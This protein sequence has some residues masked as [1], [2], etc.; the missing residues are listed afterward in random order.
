MKCA[1]YICF[2]IL[3][4]VFTFSVTAQADIQQKISEN[5][6]TSNVQQIKPPEQSNTIVEVQGAEYSLVERAFSS[7]FVVSFVLLTLIFFS[8]L[9]WAILAAKWFYLKRIKRHNDS[10]IAAFWNS[11][12]INAFHETLN[13][14]PY[15]P[16]R[17]VF[18][19]GYQELVKVT[20]L[21]EKNIQPD[22][23][24]SVTRVNLSRSL[25]KAKIYQ[26]ALIE[27]FLFLL[28]IISSSAPFIGLFGTVWGI[29]RAFEGIARTGDA[30]LSA[31]APG[32]SEALIA[33]AFGLAAAIPASIGYNFCLVRIR[34]LLSSLDHFNHGFL[35]TVERQLIAKDDA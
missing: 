11:N 33:T 20:G 1:N 3:V 14:E 9:T 16:A 27:R 35:N 23:F 2:W 12:S 28:A 13:T 7:G 19:E 18:R 5:K 21:R 4:F 6:Q 15:S 24:L 32:I 34:S 22:I 26:K 30:S 25:E 29:M 17:E 31:V 8:I 10:F